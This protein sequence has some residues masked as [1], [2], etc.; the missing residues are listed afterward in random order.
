MNLSR[1]GALTSYQVQR[2]AQVRTLKE[3][4]QARGTHILSSAEGGSI[5]DTKRI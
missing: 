4:E 5:Q 3:S 1:E 2:E